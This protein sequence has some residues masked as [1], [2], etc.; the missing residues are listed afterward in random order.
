MTKWLRI[1][2]AAAFLLPISFALTAPVGAATAQ[3]VGPTDVAKA[4]AVLD[5]ALALSLGVADQERRGYVLETAAGAL[6][7]CDLE[8]AL[9]V[10]R[11]LQDPESRARALSAVIRGL[12]EATAARVPEVADE[13]LPAARDIKDWE[14]RSH[15]LVI[16]LIAVGAKG[17]ET[18]GS[19]ATERVANEALAAAREAPDERA[20]ASALATVATQ[21]YFLRALAESRSPERAPSIDP[22]LINKA[23]DEA[24]AMTARLDDDRMRMEMAGL[25]ALRDPENA[26]E[27]ARSLKKGPTDQPRWRDEALLR[28]AAALA[29]KQPEK[30]FRVSREIEDPWS[31]SLA[32]RRLGY[33]TAKTAPGSI[34]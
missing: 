19:S 27:I 31:R 26:L 1:V 2:V 33:A 13:A 28:V 14:A 7:S 10:A 30:A 22:A 4:R 5:E 9:N 11:S 8:A 15:T 20:R 18:G 24:L 34:G 32:L 16:L 29:L 23:L 12:P 25:T 3:P 17:V 6:A 21:L